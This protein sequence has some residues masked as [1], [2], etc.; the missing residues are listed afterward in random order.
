M[1]DLGCPSAFTPSSQFMTSTLHTTQ[2]QPRGFTVSISCS[3]IRT[4][5]IHALK[6]R[7]S[8]GCMIHPQQRL[9]FTSRHPSQDA[10]SICELS[11]FVSS[12]QTSRCVSF[13]VRRILLEPC[14]VAISI[15]R[16]LLPSWHPRASSQRQSILRSLKSTS[17]SFPVA[18]QRDSPLLPSTINRNLS[19]IPLG[20]LEYIPFPHHHIRL[21]HTPRY[22]QQWPESHPQVSPSWLTYRATPTSTG[23]RH[24]HRSRNLAR[25][26]H[27][28]SV[29]VC[30]PTCMHPIKHSSLTNPLQAPS[31][32]RR[33]S[34]AVCPC[35]ALLRP[36]THPLVWASIR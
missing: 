15:E 3:R 32:H 19:S 31:H 11:T 10:A 26:S 12:Q 34:S 18:L 27:L 29:V 1:G 24:R 9:C 21:T 2:Q 25:A 28:R 6:R 7:P 13:T 14:I 33:S 20:I 23:T 35:P 17:T 8:S 5:T 22:H 16:N 30:L 36:P 4:A